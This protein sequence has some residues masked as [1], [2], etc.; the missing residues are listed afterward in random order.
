[1]SLTC[2]VFGSER[3]DF[4]VHAAGKGEGGIT[5]VGVR[6]ELGV[7]LFGYCGGVGVVF[8]GG[9]GLG[10]DVQEGAVLEGCGGDVGG[11]GARVEFVV[12]VSVDGEG[13]VAYVVDV[14]H[15]HVG[16]G[17]VGLAVCVLEF[18]GKGDVTGDNGFAVGPG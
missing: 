2:Y 9:G 15:V 7:V 13:D 10:G 6:E 5:R 14:L 17:G 16:M 4:I 3:E 1:V 11:H 18:V 12:S 8:A